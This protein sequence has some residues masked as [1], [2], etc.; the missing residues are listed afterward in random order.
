MTLEYPDNLIAMTEN[1]IA[2]ERKYAKE[3]I[4]YGSAVW[5]DFSCTIDGL[6]EQ[7]EEGKSV[8]EALHNCA[9]L[10]YAVDFFDYEPTLEDKYEAWSHNGQCYSDEVCLQFFDEAKILWEKTDVYKWE[11]LTKRK[12]E[13]PHWMQLSLDQKIDAVEHFVFVTMEIKK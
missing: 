9:R 3:G 1:E 13:N 8:E 7:F 11:Y 10:G 2:T 4:M 6:L 5:T 12:A